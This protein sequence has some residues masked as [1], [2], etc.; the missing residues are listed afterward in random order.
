MPEKD[1]NDFPL[2]ILG[3]WLDEIIK[4]EFEGA[5]KLS[6][7]DGPFF[8]AIEKNNKEDCQISFWDGK[9]HCEGEFCY[10]LD[11]LNQAIINAAKKVL[12]FCLNNSLGASKD[13]EL[14]EHKLRL[15]NQ[16]P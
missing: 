16:Q 12:N 7:M 4:L 11:F 10:K 15:F 8:V 6:F 9:G 2:I 14:V 3:W 13:I 1:W 5:A